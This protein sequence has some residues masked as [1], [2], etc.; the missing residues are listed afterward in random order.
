MPW[1][2]PC[3]YRHGLAPLRVAQ[4]FRVHDAHNRSGEHWPRR[5]GTCT[6]RINH[7]SNAPAV[8][9][10]LPRAAAAAC[11]MTA[12]L[13]LRFSREI[14]PLCLLNYSSRLAQCA[15]RPLQMIGGRP[16]RCPSVH[17][18]AR[19][20]RTTTSVPRRRSRSARRARCPWTPLT[21]MAA[22]GCTGMV[23][24]T[25]LADANVT[26][27]GHAPRAPRGARSHSVTMAGG[28]CR[29]A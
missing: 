7:R 25:W 8:R 23:A 2:V 6:A 28:R 22:H 21:C 24:L 29:E 12:H 16:I 19:G 11:N 26:S 9:G 20:R 1:T 3:C 5:A 17:C 27:A 15:Q 4:V 14:L 10:R 18:L 13:V